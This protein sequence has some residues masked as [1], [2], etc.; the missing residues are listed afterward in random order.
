MIDNNTTTMA[1]SSNALEVPNKET[2]VAASSAST[3]R[4]DDEVVQE[5]VEDS[6]VDETVEDAGDLL[7]DDEYPSGL[8]M[9]FIVLALV[10]SVFLFSL[11]LV[12]NPPFTIPIG[13][14]NIVLTLSRPSSL[15]LSLKSPMSS[16]VSTRLD[17]TEHPSS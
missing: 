15:L 9:F 8:K 1:V 6:T 11:D 12:R 17:G 3:L 10:L 13:D 4:G 16:R 14:Q 2:E 5:K 7:N